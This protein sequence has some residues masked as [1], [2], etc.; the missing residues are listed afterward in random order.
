[1]SIKISLKKNKLGKSTVNLVLFIDEN[2]SLKSV[3][4]YISN[5]EFLYISDLLK[6]NDL[7]KKLLIFEVN[8]KKK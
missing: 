7:K 5:S 8:S 4:K 6:T 1:M 3:K 2:F